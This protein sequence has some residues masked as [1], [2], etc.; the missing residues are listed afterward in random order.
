MRVLGLDP[1]ATTGW[2]LYVDTDAG[3]YVE[4]CGEFDRHDDC[5]VLRE[6]GPRADAVVIESM[7]KPRGSIY[8]ATVL[9]AI[10]EGRLQERV[11][12][13]T[14]QEP[15]LISRHDVK[16]ELTAA[17]QRTAVVVD[18]KTA[19]AA[20]VLLHGD[21]SARKPKRRKGVVVDAGGPLGLVTGHARAAL[22]VAVAFVLRRSL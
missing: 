12:R 10:T 8:P 13:A 7:H 16:L 11:V 6:H 2:C 19:W 22:A 21:D 5:G 3:R 15:W 1:G 20:L 17:T 14:G 18:D 4:A 9:S